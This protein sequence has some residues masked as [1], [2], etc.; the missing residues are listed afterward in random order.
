M[1]LFVSGFWVSF[2]KQWKLSDISDVGLQSNSG[3][4]ALPAPGSLLL[5]TAL[6]S[7]LLLG[8]VGAPK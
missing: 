8:A 4:G 2:K 6:S 7:R 5:S 1:G 3:Q